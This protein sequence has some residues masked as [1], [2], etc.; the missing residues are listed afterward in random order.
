MLQKNYNSKSV[1]AMLT[2]LSVLFVTI[3]KNTAVN[4]LQQYNVGL[5]MLLHSCLN[6][7]VFYHLRVMF[8]M[9][10]WLYLVCY[11]HRKISWATHEKLMKSHEKTWTP[12]EICGLSMKF[13]IFHILYLGSYSLFLGFYVS[14]Y[15]FYFF[16]RA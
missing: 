16:G 10:P 2:G 4:H 1:I 6:R 7:S 3:H 14:F 11:P 8:V 15:L 9:V 12:W 13:L 5:L